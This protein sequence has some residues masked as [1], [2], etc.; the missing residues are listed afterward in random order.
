MSAPGVFGHLGQARARKQ[1]KFPSWDRR[2]NEPRNEASGVVL[3]KRE[4]SEPPYIFAQRSLLKTKDALSRD[5]KGGSLRSRYS[6]PPRSPRSSACPSFP[7]GQ[8]RMPVP[9]RSKGFRMLQTT[10][11]LFD[12]DSIVS[13]RGF[14]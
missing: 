6:V 13:Q 5:F 12:F 1:I 8:N 10:T 2:G 9:L 3:Q 11:A 7:G 14:L 4:R